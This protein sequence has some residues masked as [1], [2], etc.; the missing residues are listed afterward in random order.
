MKGSET[1]VPIQD[2]NQPYAHPPA[3]YKVE[4]SDQGHSYVVYIKTAGTYQVFRLI[5]APRKTA[6]KAYGQNPI[7][8]VHVQTGKLVEI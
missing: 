2:L 8:S 3:D 1:G 6:R 7:K 4:F 5:P